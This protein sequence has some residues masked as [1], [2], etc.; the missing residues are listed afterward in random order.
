MSKNNKSKTN[1]L[2]RPTP[3]QVDPS[4]ACSPI[5]RRRVLEKIDHNA[6][7]I[8]NSQQDASSL[9][10]LNEAQAIVPGPSE[11]A[12]PP[13]PISAATRSGNNRF[14]SFQLNV[15]LSNFNRPNTR[16]REFYKASEEEL[17][18]FEEKIKHFTELAKKREFPEKEFFIDNKL[19]K[20]S[21]IYNLFH[22]KSSFSSKDEL[23]RFVCMVCCVIV[24]DKVKHNT[25]LHHH[26]KTHSSSGDRKLLEWYQAFK[27]HGSQKSNKESKF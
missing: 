20:K 10:Q 23:A 7:Q 9:N 14:L 22:S 27:A 24:T 5:T 3:I 21:T 4:A 1:T 18:E 13:T 25:N 17:V 26:I 6:S 12:L 2:K 8:S 11:N 19:R 16:D 15:P